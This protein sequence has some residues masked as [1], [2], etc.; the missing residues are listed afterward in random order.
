M[1]LCFGVRIKKQTNKQ[2]E[3]LEY[4]TLVVSVGNEWYGGVGLTMGG[5]S[6]L[7]LGAKAVGSGEEA[8]SRPE[9]PSV[10]ARFN[11]VS[12]VAEF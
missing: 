7:G 10:E 11:W 6:L 2:T 1:E 8:L 4:H 12:C 5:V 3:G 9:G